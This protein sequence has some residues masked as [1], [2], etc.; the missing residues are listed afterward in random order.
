M[1]N[2][3]IPKMVRFLDQGKNDHECVVLRFFILSWSMSVLVGLIP[4]QV[5]DS[6]EEVLRLVSN[7][8]FLDGSN[9][10]SRHITTIIAF[11][12]LG[13][14]RIFCLF[15]DFS[16]ERQDG[17]LS[18]QLGIHAQIFIG[19]DFSFVRITRQRD[20]LK[21]GMCLGSHKMVLLN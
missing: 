5:L 16:V 15:T 1:S 2:V 13:S 4:S 8:R 12:P 10:E 18:H 6:Q 14:F 20:K 7:Q 21:N 11:N 17:G 9:M 3:C 19:S